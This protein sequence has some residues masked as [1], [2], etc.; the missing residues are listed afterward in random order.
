VTAT[1]RE[2][3]AVPQAA[4]VD[5]DERDDGPNPVGVMLIAGFLSLLIFGGGIYIGFT[6]NVNRWYDALKGMGL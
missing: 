4:V 3:Q 5:D 6:A 2:P 1:P